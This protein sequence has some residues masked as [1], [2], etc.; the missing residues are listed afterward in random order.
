MEYTSGNEIADR[1]SAMNFSGNVIPPTWF[2]TV[3][4]EKGKP[5]LLAII[6][7]SEIVYWYRPIEIRDEETGEFVGYRT[8]F[9]KDL[10]QKS[11]QSLAEYYHVSKRQVTAAIV[12][13]EKIGVI[14]R[15]FREITK[16]GKVYNN[17]LFIQLY[18]DKL[19]ELTY[20]Q[21]VEPKN[22]KDVENAKIIDN[23]PLPQKNVTGCHQKMEE[24]PTKKCE[25]NTENTKEITN[26]TLNPIFSVH[27]DNYKQCFLEQ[28]GYDVIKADY[29]DDSAASAVL[30]QCVEIAV[31]V[32]NSKKRKILVNSQWQPIGIVQQ[33]LLS[34]NLSHMRFVIAEFLKNKTEVKKIRSYLLTC[35]VNAVYGL[36]IKTANN[37]IA[38][39]KQKVKTNIFNS[40]PQREISKMQMDSLEK[41][42]LCA[43]SEYC[44]K[45]V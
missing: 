12:A 35:M 39:S 29:K 18:P 2:K 28:I 43:R 41:K 6:I 15:V 3:T 13:L 37:R 7:L 45:S 27:E 22:M 24:P 42:L 25:T 21:R 31:C 16:A 30:E 9:K 20:P 36:E 38:N 40:F 14:K 19:Q 26:N 44:E 10:L 17:V 4:K 34:L 23:T 11:Y 8:K 33:K 5:Y 32:L 1:L